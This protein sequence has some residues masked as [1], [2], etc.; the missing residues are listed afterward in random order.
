MD[1]NL[2]CLCVFEFMFY[3]LISRLPTDLL[4]RTLQALLKTVVCKGCVLVHGHACLE[5]FM[6]SMVRASDQFTKGCGS[7]LVRESELLLFPCSCHADRFITELKLN[8]ISSA[9]FCWELSCSIW[10]LDIMV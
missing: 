5:S 9:H 1:A 2:F 6:S 4:N 10:M 3:V 7:I 8:N